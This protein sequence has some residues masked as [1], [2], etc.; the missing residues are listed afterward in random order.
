M[1]ANTYKLCIWGEC[2]VGKTSLT[3]QFMKRHF[4]E[5]YD[6]T[7]EEPFSNRKQVDVDDELALVEILDTAGF[8]GI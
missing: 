5:E 8:E 4:V 7:I 3:I 1:I 6:P 2:G